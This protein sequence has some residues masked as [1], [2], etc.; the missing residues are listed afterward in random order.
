MTKQAADQP[1]ARIAGFHQDDEGV[2]V[3]ELECGHNQ[4]VRHEPPFKLAPWV[5]SE[6][7]RREKVG[8][9]LPCDFCRMP[10]IPTRARVYKSTPTWGDQEVPKGLRASH[11]LKADTWARIVVEHGRVAYVLED[12]GDFMLI[13]R[14]GVDGT[15]GPGRSHHIAPVAGARL[16]IEFLRCED[17]AP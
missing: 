12:Q 10:K 7:S 1:T 15:V 5:T 6:A 17:D 2:W 16:H 3:A 8:V 13:L 4:H 11:T 9:A 14:P